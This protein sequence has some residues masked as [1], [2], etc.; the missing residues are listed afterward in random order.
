MNKRYLGF[1]VH[2]NHITVA[3]VDANQTLVLKPRKILVAHFAKWLK[4]NLQPTDDVV[5]EAMSGCWTTYDQVAPYCNRVVVAHPYK[6]K[7][8]ASSMVKTDRR[9]AV[10]LARLLAAHI[11]PTVWVPP[12]H[13]RELRSLVRHREALVRQRA[14]AKTRLRAILRHYQ[15]RGPKGVSAFSRDYWQ[16]V[17]VP[18]IER[19]R[20]RHAIEL[21][22]LL[23]QQ[24]NEVEQALTQLSVSPDWQDEVPYLL[25]LP[26]IGLITAMT[27]LSAIGT[28]SRFPSAKNLVGYAGLGARVHASGDSVKSGGITKQGR[29]EL[30]T[31]MIEA[32]WNAIRYSPFWR[33][34]HAQLAQRLGRQKA[35][36][37]IARKLLV[38]VW[39]VLRHRQADHQ[40]VANTVAKSFWR[41][42]S[43]HRLAT[44]LGMTP[45]AFA[46]HYLDHLQ[47]GANLQQITFSY[48]TLSL[49]PPRF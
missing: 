26:G 24:I 8:I 40:A 11:L 22:E 39:H 27:L 23:S 20:A 16:T 7:L 43:R 34:R 48:Q 29:R 47:L 32:A 21:I 46:R 25:Q 49:P 41:W 5:I 9:D 1:D 44:S 2:Q 38:V 30:R 33:E 35:A 28:I 31:A 4:T 14:S 13:V 42:G 6:V 36:V 18:E 12:Q 45:R 3:G 10:T 37:V 17:A 19:L 15:V